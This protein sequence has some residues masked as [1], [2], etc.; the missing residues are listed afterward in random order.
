MQRARETIDTE[1]RQQLYLKGLRERA[2]EL[3]H[4]LQIG[5]FDAQ[6]RQ[7][8]NELRELRKRKAALESELQRL[9]RAM[10]ELEP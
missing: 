9:R 8:E 6:I 2:R 1:K 5:S 3:E 7:R 10:G 4:K